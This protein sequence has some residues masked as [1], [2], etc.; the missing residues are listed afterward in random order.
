MGMP[1]VAVKPSIV[2]VLTQVANLNNYRE[3]MFSE[4]VY[5]LT[6]FAIWFDNF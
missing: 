3:P 4:T 1:T 6:K 5:A 2:I